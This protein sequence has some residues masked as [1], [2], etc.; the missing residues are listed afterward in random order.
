MPKQ[1]SIMTSLLKASYFKLKQSNKRLLVMLFLRSG[2]IREF[3]IQTREIPIK[4][5]GFVLFNFIICR[6]PFY[7]ELAG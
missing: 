1:I 5:Y 6:K 2:R 4:E 7:H 3:L